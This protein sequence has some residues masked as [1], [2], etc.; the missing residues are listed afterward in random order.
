MVELE[1]PLPFRHPTPRLGKRKSGGNGL[2]RRNFSSPPCRPDLFMEPIFLNYMADEPQVPAQP[3]GAGQPTKKKSTPVNLAMVEAAERGIDLTTPA[4]PAKPQAVAAV[5]PDS[6]P[7]VPAPEPKHTPLEPNA[8]VPS[9]SVEPEPNDSA[10]EA[11]EEGVES[12]ESPAESSNVEPEP[13]P[14]DSKD[15]IGALAALA[16]SGSQKRL[17]PRD[18]DRATALLRHCLST[19]ESAAALSAMPKLPWILGVRA[20]EQAWPQLDAEG[21]TLLLEQLSTMESEHAV[22]LRLSVARSLAKIDPPVGVALAGAVAKVMW[23]EERGALSNDHSKLVGNVFIGRGKPWILQLSL[24]GLE[25]PDADAIVSSV[26]YSAFNVNN[27]PITQLSILRYAGPRLAGLHANLLA[28]VAKGVSRWSGKWQDSLRKEVADLPEAI[29]GTLKPARPAKTEGKEER[30]P[31]K[32]EGKTESTV[33][34][35]E[36]PL[37]SELEEKLKLAVESGDAEAVAA[38][39]LEANAWRDAQAAAQAT[40]QP[41]EPTTEES[42][43]TERKG[44]KRRRGRNERDR[45]RERERPE[46]TER[47]A[48]RK[49]RPAYVSREQEAAQKGGGFNLSATL[50]Q[51]E[52]HVSQLRN[53]L[54]NTQSKLRKAESNVVR[55]SSDKVLLS[56]EEANLSTDELK[57]LILQLER[58]NSELQFRVEE[59]L[60][61]SETRALATSADADITVQ[62]RTLLKLKLQEDYS[63]YLALEKNLPEYVVQQHYRSLIRHVFGV[64]REEGVTLEGDLPPPPPEPLPPP[65]PPPVIEDEEDEEDS[66]L[67]QLDAEPDSE[68]AEHDA[69]EESTEVEAEESDDESTDADADVDEDTDT[70]EA[71]ESEAEDDTA[72][73]DASEEVE[74]TEAEAT[75]ADDGTAPVEP[76]KTSEREEKKTEA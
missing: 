7:V 76:T 14:D 72:A 18:E 1:T 5:E 62:Y 57:R 60:A 21:K 48:E 2:W 55:K 59:L 51:I 30:T 36:I 10:P 20:I 34:E 41:A 37:P 13:A 39:T 25:A 22:R 27:P 63:D 58:R 19:R 47:P 33:E 52:S 28:M 43:E 67:D 32:T 42:T 46:R 23:N 69:P 31:G 11:T 53:E 71:D 73:E 68:Q 66:A 44:D 29:S 4:K 49:E 74:S 54:S 70:E 75:P 24:D 38:A 12:A 65:P 26:V 45:D 40:A 15:P 61:D 50:K 35:T 17:S 64:L 6:T 56:V 9:T 16:E 3:E 8:S